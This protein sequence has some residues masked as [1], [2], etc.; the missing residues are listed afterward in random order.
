MKYGELERGE[1]AAELSGMEDKQLKELLD[2]LSREEEKISYKRRVIHGKI[3][4]LRAELV[5][6]LKGKQK[7]GER[8]ISKSDIDRLSEI[9]A[10]ETSGS[11]GET[12]EEDVF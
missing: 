2:K 5:S 10:S 8:L 3:D 6:R 1:L 12:S 7:R 4:V 9:L 11:V